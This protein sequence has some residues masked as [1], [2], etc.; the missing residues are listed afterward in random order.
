MSS[1]LDRIGAGLILSKPEVFGFD[2]IPNVIVGRESIQ[3][4]LAA[5]FGSLAHIQRALVE[6]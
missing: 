4:D 2:Y 1:Y 3:G 5:V 6:R